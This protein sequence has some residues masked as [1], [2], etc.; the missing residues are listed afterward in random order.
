[1]VAWPRDTEA[2]ERFLC[3]VSAEQAEIMNPNLEVEN[4]ETMARLG[5]QWARG[6]GGACSSGPA[7]KPLLLTLP[8]ASVRDEFHRAMHKLGWPGM[9]WGRPFGSRATRAKGPGVHQPGEDDRS[10]RPAG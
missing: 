7:E 9:S 3:V 10:R 6:L 2:R 1:M 5:G 4:D 8:L